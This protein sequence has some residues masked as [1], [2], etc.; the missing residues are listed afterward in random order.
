MPDVDTSTTTV[1]EALALGLKRHGITDI[2]GQS[3]PSAMFLATQQLGI[4][5]ITYRTENAGGAMA[6]ANAAGIGRVREHDAVAAHH[7]I[8][9]VSA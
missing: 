4:R 3:L 2:F 7:R 8:R 9:L 5:Q 1:A 6:G